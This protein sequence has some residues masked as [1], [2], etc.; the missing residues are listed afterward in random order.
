MDDTAEDLLNAVRGIEPLIRQHA[1]EAELNR[2]E[3]SQC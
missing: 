3:P 2:R 1:D